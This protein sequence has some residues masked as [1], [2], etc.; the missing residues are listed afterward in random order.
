[1]KTF[2]VANVTKKSNTLT[3]KIEKNPLKSY[4]QF[5]NFLVPTAA[6]DVCTTLKLIGYKRRDL[7]LGVTFLSYLKIPSR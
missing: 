5:R 6:P 7:I 1:M 4:D 3:K 2:F